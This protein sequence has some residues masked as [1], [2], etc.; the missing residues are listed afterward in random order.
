MRRIVMLLCTVA[1]A[2]S[3]ARADDLP[4]TPFTQDPL[5]P[6][7][8]VTAN[9]ASYQ[10]R[11]AFCVRPDVFQFPG[12]EASAS[13][14]GADADCAAS[15][16]TATDSG[17]VKIRTDGPSGACGTCT[18]ALGSG[19]RRLFIDFSKIPAN[20]PPLL[21][22]HGHAYF[23]ISSFNPSYTIEPVAHSPNI[24]NFTNDKLF[25]PD[26]SPQQPFVYGF[27]THS[28]AYT[29]NTAHTVHNA[30]QGPFYTG[31]WYVNAAGERIHGAYL[32][33]EI[34]PEYAA[35]PQ[36]HRIN[37]IGYGAGFHSGEEVCFDE[38]V[39]R[40]FGEQ[41]RDGDGFYGGCIDAFGAGRTTID[42]YA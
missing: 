2:S 13:Y 8:D 34:S 20:A 10:P 29:A 21:Y 7:S 6:I 15:G 35:P 4:A 25:V 1:L 9:A 19:R 30:D 17:L 12:P 33:V 38:V 42:P 22:A 16:F 24:K 31:P 23:H 3:V 14:T 18:P 5:G 41:Y 28:R 37:E 40:R 26:G 36:A 39:G 32:D 27:D 11:A